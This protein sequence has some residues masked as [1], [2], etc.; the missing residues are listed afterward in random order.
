MVTKKELE[1]QLISSNNLIAE[2][3]RESYQLI[4]TTKELI[5]QIEGSH[6]NT[7]EENEGEINESKRM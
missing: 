7:G 5:K 1:K 2:Y 4:S 3:R 6:K